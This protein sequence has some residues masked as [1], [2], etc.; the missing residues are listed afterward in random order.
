M[1]S[2]DD[3]LACSY[4]G[5]PTSLSS[6]D[7]DEGNHQGDAIYCC[8]GC[9]I[10]SGIMQ[11]DDPAVGNRRALT[12]LGMAIFF[13]M[14]VM[15]FTLVLW[16]WN[17]RDLS[18]DPAVNA[19]RETLR[20]AC[21]L[22]SAPVLILLGAPLVEA[23]LDAWYQRRF[24][25]DVLLLLG[26]CAA[27]CYSIVSLVFG[28]PDVYFEVGCMILVAVTLG[29]WLEATAK[30]KATHAL[31]S[32]R[33]L[34]PD[35]VRRMEDE[36]EVV[37]PLE[38]VQPNDLLRVLAGERIPVDGVI[39]SGGGT[40]DEQVVT[41]ESIPNSKSANDSVFSGTLNLDGDLYVRASTSHDDGT[42]ARLA[43][44][45]EQATNEKCRTMRLADRLAAWF[46]PLIVAASIFAFWFNYYAG[47]Q[48]ALMASLSVV[49]IACPCALGIATPLA[50]WVAI[51]SAASNGVLFRNGDAVT[52]LA[53]LRALAFDKTGT[54]TRGDVRVTSEVFE[55]DDSEADAHRYARC[56]AA[57][58][59][60]VLSQ[61]IASHLSEDTRD[62]LKGAAPELD[63]IRD[64]AGKGVSGFHLPFAKN[65]TKV[66][67]VA[68]AR[69]NV[70]LGSRRLAE[71]LEFEIP[72]ALSE[73]VTG[74]ADRAVVYVG[75]DGRVRGLFFLSEELRPEAPAILDQLQ[76][77]GLQLV[78]LTGDHSRRARQF[79]SLT[80]VCALGDLLP[81]DKVTELQRLPKP[82]GMV[83]DGIND[84]IALT[85]AD[86]GIAMDC[87]ADVSRDA[88]DVCLMG[89][90]LVHLPQAILLARA[91]TKT[92]RRNLIWAVGYNVVG[93]GFA[94][95]GNLNPIIAAIAMVG[96]SLFVLTSSLRL[97]AFATETFASI[98]KKPASD[99]AASDFPADFERVVSAVSGAPQ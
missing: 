63:D 3:L 93:I 9:R 41:G 71:E 8:L 49:L 31:R 42:I 56:L 38:A 60:H 4:C 99:V 32:L 58:S 35:S 80:G 78:I 19:F 45:V 86:V 59:N 83:G 34:L 69:P 2:A 82:V 1:C 10:A 43:R 77:F 25:T 76:Q 88:A 85:V 12:R 5:L 64:N 67:G 24:T 79:E 97:A 22:F 92:V 96:S 52:D 47:L 51:S 61:A 90:T 26:V 36:R 6:R 57:S 65:Q 54:V 40:V 84:A 18:N 74:N 55:T 53:S 70:M 29:K 91:A 11:S 13:T 21:F 44:A 89:S 46:V 50:L 16:T 14:N 17:V 94:V 27:Y 39:D 98:D 87:G 95:M 72:R 7:L 30:L 62:E 23:S 75:W 33:Q 37:V 81:E 20:Y 68:S 73:Q 48:H 15:V 66:D 28:F